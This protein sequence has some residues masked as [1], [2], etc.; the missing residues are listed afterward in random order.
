MKKIVVVFLLATMLIASYFGYNYFSSRNLDFDEVSHYV[1]SDDVLPIPTITHKI[2]ELENLLVYEEYP[3]NLDISIHN[4][5]IKVG[6]RKKE[7][8]KAKFSKLIEVLEYEINF[9]F[10]VNA[11]ET[12][13]RDV[14]VFQKNKKIVGIVKICFDC[15]KYYS[16]GENLPNFNFENYDQLENLLEK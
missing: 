16:I 14:L 5:L 11:C 1:I 3:Q 6:Y 8:D 13:Y 7:I 10:G 9:K 4:E 15:G 2:T 12:T